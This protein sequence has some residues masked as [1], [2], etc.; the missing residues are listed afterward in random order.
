MN[1][2]PYN[3]EISLENSTFKISEAASELIKKF[4][5]SNDGLTLKNWKALSE[6]LDY[7]AAAEQTIA[8][9]KEY[10]SDLESLA[11]TDILTGLL[12]RNGFEHEIIHAI[13]RAKRYNETSLVAYIDLDGFKAVNDT[14][15]HN[16]GDKMLRQ[17]GA[18]LNASIRQTDDAAR[19]SGD[20]FGILLTKCDIKKGKERAGFI[21]HNLRKITVN[22]DGN[23]LHTSAS[24]GFAVINKNSVLQEVFEEADQA[25]YQNKRD[26][27]KTRNKYHLS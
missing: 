9:Q 16:A 10:I 12:N 11:A 6:I 7:A 23:E 25:M 26:R 15:G 8:D 1:I 24:M 2:L 27:M 19:L 22:H 14:Y 4:H 3:Q 13:A 20:E 17:V 18:I 5:Q 21:R